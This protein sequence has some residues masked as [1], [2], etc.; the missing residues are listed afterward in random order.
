MEFSRAYELMDIELQCVLRNS[1]GICNRDCKNCDLVQK[2][3]D[4]IEAYQMAK[5]ALSYFV[6]SVEEFVRISEKDLEKSLERNEKLWSEAAEELKE[7][8]IN[9]LNQEIKELERWINKNDSSN[10]DNSSV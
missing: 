3:T 8:R 10:M 4:L 7:K 1:T 6:P 9:A 5:Y 2:D